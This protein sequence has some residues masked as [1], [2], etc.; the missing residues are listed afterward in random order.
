MI[1]RLIVFA[2]LPVAGRVKTR[3]A[4]T[5]GDARALDVH[6]RLL[7]ATIAL[8]ESGVADRLEFRHA[9]GDGPL[10]D[11]ARALPTAL[12][13]RGWSTGP[14]RGADLGERMRD[15]L[16]AA[17]AAGDRPVLV[18]CD[19]PSLRPDDLVAAFDALDRA[20]ACLA[21]A[22]DGGYALVG[23]ARP[24]PTLFERM[25]WGT[26]A[27]MAETLAR[28]A[29]SGARAVLLRTVWD[30]DVEADLARWD[31]AGPDPAPRG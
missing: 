7:A 28:L 31:A 10:P 5:V 23:I 30:V 20:D 4:A 19:C 18:G 1:R 15:A 26:S 21:P 11:D 6:R 17:L 3:L 22:E 16:E 14:Q 24:L 25:P 27:V 13:A 29:A 9:G 2:R 8:A 12:A